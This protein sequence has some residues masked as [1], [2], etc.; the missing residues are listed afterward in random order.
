MKDKVLQ[1]KMF[2]Q[3][4][5]KKY[6]GDMLPKFNTSGLM[7]GE[8][9]L[10]PLDSGIARIRKVF[11]NFLNVTDEDKNTE[12]SIGQPYDSKQEM[13]LA[14]AG[15]LLQA[16]QRPGEGM[17]SGVGRGVGKAITE[18]FPI[19]NKLKLEDRSLKAKQLKDLLGTGEGAKY[20]TD[21][22]DTVE[23]Q[24]VPKVP[25]SQVQANPGRYIDNISEITWTVMEDLPDLG[26]KQYDTYYMTPKVRYEKL[27]GP[28]KV[29][30]LQEKL[31]PFGQ[32]S[33][34]QKNK[35]KVAT[36][37]ESNENQLNIELSKEARETGTKF[38]ALEQSF[39]QLQKIIEDDA[40]LL[41]TAGG[42][43]KVFDS[44]Q[45][46]I[47]NLNTIVHGKDSAAR[48]RAESLDNIGRDA[49]SEVLD[50]ALNAKDRDGILV[51]DYKFKGG[52]TLQAIQEF[53]SQSARHKAVFTELLYTIAKFREEG[54][55]FSV[56]DI[57]LAAQSL[58]L[59]SSKG[60]ALG[61]MDALRE[62]F[63]RR[64]YE[65][66][67]TK[68]GALVEQRYKGLLPPDYNK[69]SK[70]EKN[71]ILQKLFMES[72]PIGNNFASKVFERYNFYENI[73]YQN[74]EEAKKNSES[75]KKQQQDIVDKYKP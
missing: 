73:Q 65:E 12:P 27:M 52:V 57:E 36:E 42:I 8:E 64:A 60:Q 45:A 68:T 32:L 51:S 56:S 50:D 75:I 63:A 15:R 46:T 53:A 37:K 16:D 58:G 13:L 9:K 28:N 55:R 14:V 48:R 25:L 7:E 24:N 33:E 72:D 19:I 6:G 54:G 10:G 66:I 2:R 44:V 26:K 35:I 17:F 71:L 43:T 38:N 31:V 62:N 21:Y 39:G 70:Y 5:L 30:G 40:T 34:A 41:G 29:E 47:Q 18:D 23:K 61:A 3:K 11:P 67:T 74:A 4:A 49:A 22:F 59:G 69:K 20:A 1:R